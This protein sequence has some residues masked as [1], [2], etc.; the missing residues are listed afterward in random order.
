MIGGQRRGSKFSITGGG[1]VKTVIFGIACLV[2]ISVGVVFGQSAH[3]LG[4]NSSAAKPAASSTVQAQ[5]ADI[6]SQRAVL[7][8]YC[9]VCHN[10]K[11]KTANLELDKLDLAHLGEHAETGE[12]IVR[13]LR[14]GM[15]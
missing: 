14:A 6:A 4:A 15:M 13:K 2:P 11:L 1:S 5:L 7:D 3:G 10:S 9:G 8:R 12:K